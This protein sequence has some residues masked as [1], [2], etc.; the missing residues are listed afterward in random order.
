[1]DYLLVATACLLLGYF[2]PKLVK[3]APGPMPEKRLPRP[4]QSNRVEKI[5][6]PR[7]LSGYHGNI[8]QKI[9]LELI[10]GKT[11]PN[12]AHAHYLLTG[13]HDGCRH[14]HEGEIAYTRIDSTFGPGWMSDSYQGTACACCG[15]IL[16]EK[17]VF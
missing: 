8:F 6:A 1:M 9:Q 13:G 3:R 16:Q 11:K 7:F 12:R 2:V 15:T 14:T 4:Q 5:L 17:K 10:D